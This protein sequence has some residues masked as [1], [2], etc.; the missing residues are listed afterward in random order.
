M[1]IERLKE[2]FNYDEPI[3]INEIYN[4]MNDYSKSKVFELINEALKLSVLKR[5]DQ[6]IY[7]LVRQTIVGDSILSLYDVIEKKYI[8]SNDVRYG[9]YGIS[10]MEVNFSLST[11]IPA[12][13]EVITN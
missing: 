12:L 10:I 7:Y 1:L 11:Q 3:F 4:I 6:G 2:K 5:Y 13:I 9:I 8:K